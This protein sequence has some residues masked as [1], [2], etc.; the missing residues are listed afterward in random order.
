MKI[1]GL[2]YIQWNCDHAKEDWV[3]AQKHHIQ[4]ADTA[5]QKRVHLLQLIIKAQNVLRSNWKIRERRILK[6][7]YWSS[8]M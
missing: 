3:N 6:T 2:V 7:L 4:K 8:K 5:I 1:K